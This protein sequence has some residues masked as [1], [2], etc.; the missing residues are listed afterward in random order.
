M[1]RA[2]WI[3]RL[4][5][6]FPLA[7]SMLAAPPNILLIVSDDHSYPFLGCYGDRNVRTPNLDRLAAEG[8][9]FHCFFVTAPQCVPA[10]AS[11]MSGR[12]P[13]AIRMIRFSSPLPA[14]VVTLPDVLRSQG[15][16]FTGVGGRSYHLDGSGGGRSEI[17][18]IL[19]AHNMA[20]FSNRLDR[21]AVGSDAQAIEHLR[22]FLDVR[23][24]NRPWWFWLNFSDPHHPWTAPAELRPDPASLVVPPYLP[25][26]PG[27]REQLADYCAEINRLDISVGRV[28][29]LLEERRL[30][31]NTLVIFTADNG[32]ALPGGKGSLHDPGCRVP[33][34][35]RW[36]GV[37]RPGRESDAL[38]SGEDLAPTLL[39]V[40]GLK[41]VTEMTGRSFLALL[42]GET[43]APREYV[44][45]MRG[46]HG[47][48]EVRPDIGSSL[49]D[50]SRAVRSIR[51]KLIYN[52]TPWVR[53][54]PVD[55]AGGRAWKEM[56]AAA[57]SGH[58][59]SH[60]V[61]RFFT[62]PRPVYELYDLVEDPAELRNRAGDPD[63]SHIERELRRALVERMI[64]E[65]DPLPLPSLEPSK[66]RPA[67]SR[68]VSKGATRPDH[69]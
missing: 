49:F 63:L 2:S 25:D 45:L 68:P 40:A 51:Y 3:Q 28:L 11:L 8:M 20:T 4:M 54:Q 59:A 65:F 47:S 61:A 52:C 64:L 31:T 14:D 58:L 56:T 48:G 22:E 16:Y 39:E 24:P 27:V 33:L 1:M 29:T 19:R 69:V 18:S 46:P 13:V 36:P 41:T 44:F 10:R 34:L 42:R 66:M 57:Q 26:L 62:A 23:P 6:I 53:Y 38:L 37:V 50:L 12:S 35:V 21:V 67:S 17:A 55:S 60:F 9:K 32:L 30:V 15:G 7:G 43:S 5:T